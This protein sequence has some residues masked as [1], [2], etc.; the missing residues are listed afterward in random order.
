MRKMSDKTKKPRQS[1][2][3]VG[4]IMQKVLLLL[5]GGVALGLSGRPDAYFR[6][7]GAVAREWRNLNQ[8]ALHDAVRK[9][10]QSKLITYQEQSDGTVSLTLTDGGTSRILR[11][12]LDDMK[13]KRPARWDRIWRLVMFD[14]PE[15]KKQGRDALAAKLKQLGFYP[16]QKSVFIFPYDCKNEVDFIVELF[17]LRPY[18]RLFLVHETDIDLHLLKT[19]RL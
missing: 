19:F 7:V 12:R 3:K 16:L 5:A 8:R 2:L 18:V 11:Y 10:Y 15:T 1:R 9:L 17:E 6:I 4:P 14:I 13:I